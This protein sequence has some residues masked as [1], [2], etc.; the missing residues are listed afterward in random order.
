[1][2]T[3]DAILSQN[4]SNAFGS[5]APSNSPA[6]QKFN[7]ND[8]VMHFGREYYTMLSCDP[9]RLHCF[10]GKQSSLLHCQEEDVEAP[11]CIGL[12]EIHQRIISMGYSG[13]RVVISNIDCQPS[14]N[15]CILIFVI[16]TMH[17]SSGTVRKFVQTFLLAEQPNGY[18]ILNDI[19]RLP[20]FFDSSKTE[21]PAPKSHVPPTAAPRQSE[22]PKTTTVQPVE[23]TA[24]VAEPSPSSQAKTAPLSPPQKPAETTEAEKKISPPKNGSNKGAAAATDKP[25]S[26]GDRVQQ[27]TPVKAKEAVP[28]GPPSSW[29]KLAAVQQNRWQSGIV[30]E[31]KG[32]VASIPVETAKQQE[33]DNGSRVNYRSVGEHREPK[34]NRKERPERAERMDKTEER[35][36]YEKRE[37]Y[38]YDLAKSIYVS[39][40][41]GRIDANELRKVF[42]PFGKI[43][44]FEGVFSKGIAFIEFETVEA[45]AAAIQS[46]P[47][48]NDAPFSVDARRAS[49][50]KEKDPAGHAAGRRYHRSPTNGA[51]RE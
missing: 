34:D 29:A 46:K 20:S 32:P 18:F 5:T 7:V 26:A 25:A 39:G 3:T 37:T 33:S 30:A 44:S 42:E 22:R 9:E 35:P 2:T 4:S 47:I 28:A 38:N 45:Q 49:V 10:Y 36:K 41:A 31:S 43:K 15:G 6:P 17:W 12:D 1:M 23:P 27:A 24:S 19:M 11:V 14:M 16:G 13:A 8:I 50:R 51:T 40:I 48:Y 21:P